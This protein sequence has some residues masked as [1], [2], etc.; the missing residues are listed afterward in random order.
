MICL[1]VD[2]SDDNG[3]QEPGGVVPDPGVVMPNPQKVQM[4]QRSTQMGSN[5]QYQS[6]PFIV[7]YIVKYSVHKSLDLN[8]SER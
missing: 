4:A 3:P 1:G 8:I 5:E 2:V 7:P 6:T